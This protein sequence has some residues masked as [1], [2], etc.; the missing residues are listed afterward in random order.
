MPNTNYLECRVIIQ[1]LGNMDSELQNF[2]NKEINLS[3]SIFKEY[4]SLL[5]L[6]NFTKLA[7]IS[8]WI[9]RFEPNDI[10]RIIAN[11]KPN[12]PLKSKAKIICIEKYPNDVENYQAYYLIA[13]VRDLTNSGRKLDSGLEFY[14]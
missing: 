7:S 1:K 12:L 2:K 14:N 8:K 10:V 11:P 9:K 4:Y 6:H 3:S 5:N 13:D